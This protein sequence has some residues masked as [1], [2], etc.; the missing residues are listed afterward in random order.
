MNLR[1][2]YVFPVTSPPIPNGVVTIDQGR[3]VAVGRKPAADEI[4]DLGNVAILPGMINAH[5]HLEFS[6]LPSPLGE[7][8]MGFTDWIGRVVAH[9]RAS[10]AMTRPSVEMGLQECVRLGVTTVGEIAQPGWSEAAFEHAGLDATVFLELIGPTAERVAGALDLARRHLVPLSSRE[11][12]MVTGAELPSPIA[13][14]P[15]PDPLPEGEGRQ[16][17]HAGLGP[18]APYS[19][20]FELLRRIVALSAEHRVPVAFHLAESRAEIELLR[21]GGGPFAGLLQALNAWDPSAIPPGIRPLDYLRLLAEA[22]RALV[23][24]GNYLDDQEIGL[25]AAHADRM[26][27]VYCPRTH[28]WFGHPPDPLEKLLAA[29]ASVALGTDSRASSPDLS[30]LAEMRA[31]AARHPNVPLDVVLQLGTI[32]AARALG[33]DGEVGSLEPGKWANLAVVALPDREADD[34]HELLFD[35]TEPVIRSYY[36]GASLSSARLQTSNLKSQTS[37][38]KSQISNLKSEI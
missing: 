28:A 30:V 32:A 17:V 22:D 35:S 8:G 31:V 23:I 37:N 19:V 7:P 9:R 36:R 14:A 1:A 27:V 33:R 4:Q 26:T 6:D 11:M 25:L 13:N 29:G 38:L 18:H 5:T 16:R 21:T 24:H 2:R 10:A 20:H 34:P 3:I 12:G 15:H